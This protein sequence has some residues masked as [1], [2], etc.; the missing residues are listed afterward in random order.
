LTITLFERFPENKLRK[1]SVEVIINTRVRTAGF[2]KPT[3][4]REE[5]H[6]IWTAK[7]D[8]TKA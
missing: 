6:R 8:M 2:K 7:K 3:E 5:V 4:R 1:I